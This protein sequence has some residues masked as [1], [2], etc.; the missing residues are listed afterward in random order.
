MTDINRI[1][2][3]FWTY[4]L[5]ASV[6]TEGTTH[7]CERCVKMEECPSLSLINKGG[8]KVELVPCKI[9]QNT[10]GSTVDEVTSIS[11]ESHVC[12]PNL[13]T[14]EKE[15]NIS[16]DIPNSDSIKS[17]IKRSANPDRRPW[18]YGNKNKPSN[19]VLSLGDHCAAKASLLPNP[20]TLC[21]GINISE[22]DDIVNNDVTKDIDMLPWTAFLI[23]TFD[24]EEIYSCE[25][26]LISRRHVLTAAH[27]VDKPRLV[28][29]K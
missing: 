16:T 4:V 13:H 18:Q 3:L 24:Q 15:N 23:S 6:I 2:C 14:L 12:C 19:S 26:V 22:L 11:E 10:G 17:V 25:G 21:C 8:P 9:Q 28:L 20:D 7:N 1:K 27:C 29:Q 5:F